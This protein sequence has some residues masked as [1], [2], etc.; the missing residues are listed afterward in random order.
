MRAIAAHAQAYARAECAAPC[1]SDDADRLEQLADLL[2]EQTWVAASVIAG[3]G[4]QCSQRRH[5]SGALMTRS[6]TADCIALRAPDAA[7]RLLMLLE[8]DIAPALAP[9]GCDMQLECARAGCCARALGA[10]AADTRRCSPLHAPLA[11]V[12]DPLYAPLRW[13]APEPLLPVDQAVWA[14]PRHRPLVWLSEHTPVLPALRA[15]SDADATSARASG[16]ASPASAPEEQQHTVAAQE[17]SML[18]DFDAADPWSLLL[19]RPQLLMQPP[20]KRAAGWG[21]AAQADV[22]ITAALQPWHAEAAELQAVVAKVRVWPGRQQQ[23]AHCAPA[24]A[25]LSRRAPQE[26]SNLLLGL[27]S[28]LTEWHPP[29]MTHRLSLHRLPHAHGTAAAQLLRWC[30]GVGGL[31]RRLRALAT[32][33]AAGAGMGQTW[34]AFAAALHAEVDAVEVRTRV[35]LCHWRCLAVVTHAHGRRASWPRTCARTC[36]RARAKA[37]TCWRWARRCMRRRALWLRWRACAAVPRPATT[38]QVR[39]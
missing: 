16:G 12:P 13:L 10:A 29:T 35:R 39:A 21:V 15:I 1:S 38:C 9:P 23:R 2:L 14:G 31:L 6:R 33:L 7:L 34:Q 24:L 25:L 28:A 11:G 5:M 8:G 22:A 3:T 18:S 20:A 30:A 27:E 19:S 36:K 32:A 26:C 37:R 17:S 4:A